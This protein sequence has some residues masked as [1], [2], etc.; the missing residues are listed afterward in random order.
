MLALASSFAACAGASRH[1]TEPPA[2]KPVTQS[3]TASWYGPGFL[4]RETASGET[5]DP[6]ALT[7][8]HR[9]L[10]LGAR[11]RVTNLQ[12]DLHV[13]VRIND[14]GPFVGERIIDLSYAAA[15]AIDLVG[16]GTAQVRLEV[17]D[18]PEPIA[19]IPSSLQFTVQIGSFT[20]RTAAEQMRARAAQVANEVVVVSARVGGATYFRVRA[21]S[22]IEHAAADAEAKRL[23]RAG[24]DALVVEK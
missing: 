10:P 13:E 12:N 6:N 7:A 21:G 22:F 14:R 1:A 19:A 20:D 9:T 15:K 5:Y 4:G 16:P 11:V 24:F 3:G 2:P 8:A 17:L 23:R 18:T